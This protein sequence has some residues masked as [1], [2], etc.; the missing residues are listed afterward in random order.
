MKRTAEEDET[1][2]VDDEVES[3][4]IDAKKGKKQ[5]KGKLKKKDTKAKA[6]EILEVKT[7]VKKSATASKS[8]K[9]AKPKSKENDS[10]KNM[11]TRS[12]SSISDKKSN[13]KTKDNKVKDKSA[14]K[15]KQDKSK[16]KEEE[17]ENEDE[18]LCQICNKSMANYDD[19]KKHKVSCTK[20]PKNHVCS[21]CGKS[22][23]QKTLLNQHF[24]YRHTNK[25]KRFVCHP[26]KR[27]FELKKTLAEHNRRLHNPGD[28]AHL[29]D[30]CSRGFWHFG[31]FQL[32]RAS[33]TGVKPFQ[34]G[35]CKEKSFACAE[36]LTKH[37][38]TCGISNQY[39]CSHCGK[40]VSTPKALSIHIS[41]VHLKDCSLKCPFCEDKTFQS[42]GGYYTHLRTKH[43]VGREGQKL[44]E[45]IIEHH[46]GGEPESKED[47]ETTKDE[48][49]NE[50]KV[51]K[52]NSVEE[53][54]KQT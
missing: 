25:P 7:E 23:S 37:L 28:A 20:I 11:K 1:M 39:E 16:D 40:R 22:F 32:H 38:K 9:S 14:E 19:F 2:T 3:E 5:T 15:G 50:N 4:S 21:K 47:P 31:E 43:S 8:T 51:T 6:D 27:S 41:E 48:S 35:R 10:S 29:C 46:I 33:H 54:N 49:E 34:C 13:K 12:K 36:R 24:D 45:A 17:E 52:G 44:S 53:D 18:F 42:R 26:C 30:V